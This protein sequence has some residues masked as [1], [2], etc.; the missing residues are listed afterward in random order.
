M[1]ENKLVLKSVNELL[2]CNFYIP[3]YQRGYRWNTT[4]VTQLLDDI[5]EFALKK[6]KTTNE[7]YCLQPIVVKSSENGSWKVVDG[8]QRLTTIRLILSYMVK[9][10]LKR[11]LKEAFKKDEFSLEYETRP[12]TE[13]FLKKIFKDNSNID[14]HY[15]WSAYQAIVDWFDDKDYNECNDFL[16]TL[17]AKDDTGNPVKVIWY[18]I[19]E[20][21]NSIDLFTRINIGKIP[22]TNA[23]L[24][25]A[26]FLGQANP[27]NQSQKAN[28]KQLQIASEWDNIENTLQDNS[29][30]FFIYDKE[31][32][33]LPQ[34][35]YDTRIEYLFDLIKNKKG[36]EEQYYTF[37]KFLL[38][39]F[40]QKRTP[41][42]EPDIEAIWLD[43]K[44]YFLTFL[45]WYHERELF[46]LIGF[47]IATGS[48]L[49]DLKKKAGKK[50]T[51]KKFKKYLRSEVAKKVNVDIESLSYDRNKDQTF[52]RRV[53]L[54]M[55]IQTLIDNKK[56]QSRFP[57]DNYKRENNWDIEHVRSQA[58]SDLKGK[59]RKEWAKLVLEF[60]TGIEVSEEDLDK[61]KDEIKIL[62]NVENRKEIAQDLLQYIKNGSDDDFDQLYKK[63]SR[64]FKEE[65]P[66][67]SHSIANLALLD[68]GTNRAYKNAFFPIKRMEIIKREK[69]GT[70]VPIATKNVF[71]KAYSKRF[72]KVMY[73]NK[74]DAEDYLAAMKSILGVYLNQTEEKD[75]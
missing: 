37:Y 74:S 16:S 33:K 15:M 48:D 18:E 7:F 12:E 3:S 29:F 50:K 56:S 38:D 65:E 45:E 42:D 2:E 24:I 60:Y 1:K 70:F 41:E 63:V 23:E 28:Y 27:G 62:D 5:Y 75:D 20:E 55:N 67:S 52:I 19:T 6:N 59:D 4:Q 43:I 49:R 25:K 44:Q 10:H 68:A 14:F 66:P 58:E 31:N 17:L 22:L 72:D 32:D 54:L 36:G 13:K 8:Q 30:W 35:N 46:H 73:W 34:S 9:D 51:K 21:T 61:Q 57:F 64:T 47:L 39:D 11:P 26:L 69:E 71:M 53:L 40:K